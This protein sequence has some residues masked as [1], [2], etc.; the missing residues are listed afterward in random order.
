MTKE[1]HIFPFLSQHH[2]SARR[3]QSLAFRY[4]T[5]FEPVQ[6]NT[7]L[8]C[9]SNLDLRL[10]RVGN[11]YYRGGGPQE[12]VKLLLTEMTVAIAV[13]LLMDID[14]KLIKISRII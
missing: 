5:S 6:A 14:V 10:L 9:K 1:P 3:P 2:A 8:C 12:S 4:S 11:C 7:S 13:K